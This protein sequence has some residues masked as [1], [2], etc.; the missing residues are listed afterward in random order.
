MSSGSLGVSENGDSEVRERKQ[1]K[2]AWQ[3]RASWHSEMGQPQ[4]ETR[5][6]STCFSQV[7]I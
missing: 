7:L 5:A 4:S 6:I 2:G 3:A 1:A